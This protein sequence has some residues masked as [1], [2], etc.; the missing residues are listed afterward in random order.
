MAELMGIMLM[1]CTPPATR[2]VQ[3]PLMHALR[4]EVHRLL[5]R[6]AL[7]VDGGPGDLLGEAGGQPAGAGDV[8]GLGADG[9]EAAEDDVLHRRRVDARCAPSAP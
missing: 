5:R 7:A 9:I 4:G 8:A 3:V 1:F 6:P 2:T